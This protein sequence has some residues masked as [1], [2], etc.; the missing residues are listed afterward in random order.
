VNAQLDVRPPLATRRLLAAALGL[1]GAAA[2]VVGLVGAPLY[3]DGGWYFFRI[4]LTGEPLIPNQRVSAAIAQVPVLITWRFSDDVLVLRHAFSLGYALLPWVGLAIGWWLVR[5]RAP[6]LWVY[7]VLG[8]LALQ[9]NFS[10]VS[11]LVLTL[12]LCWPFVLAAL[13]YPERAL[14]LAYGFVLAAVLVFLHPLAFTAA[15]LLALL[16]LIIARRGVALDTQRW[17]WLAGWFALAALVRFAWTV[18]GLNTYERGRLAPEAAAGYLLPA[19]DLQLGLLIGIGLL[20][21]GWTLLVAA[22]RQPWR[23]RLT[24]LLGLTGW[25][26]PLAALGIGAGFLFGEGIRLKVGLGFVLGL[27]LMV[28]AALAVFAA[29]RRTLPSPAVRGR[30]LRQL[31]ASATAAILL[32]AAARSVAWW[33]AT[34]GLANLTASSTEICIPFGPDEPYAM[35]W[36]WMSIIDDWASP[37][38][39]LVFRGDPGLGPIALLLKHD[40]CTQLAETGIVHFPGW[41]SVPFPALEARFGPLRR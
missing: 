36:P 24:A 22:P 28:L 21:L 9:L 20:G 34:H 19:T 38:N 41:V 29:E 7:P 4:A 14:T 10:G 23:G 1:I 40:G 26:L 16:A 13:L 8:L 11:E 17:Y 37:F 25:L 12:H 32:L 5:R 15:A 39:A 2:V 27:G 3:G 30:A 35:Q 18:T 6:W 33:T 31:I